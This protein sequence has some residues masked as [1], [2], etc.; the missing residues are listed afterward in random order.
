MTVLN[1]NTDI[2]NKENPI[3][4]R[5]K[6]RS[7][8]RIQRA[9][10]LAIFVFGCLCQEEVVRFDPNNSDDVSDM[11]VGINIIASCIR[12]YIDTEVD[13]TLPFD[14]KD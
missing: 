1:P 13:P 10:A 7:V 9:N 12:N 14:W 2:V 8:R 4:A 3:T 6:S 11:Q 5:A